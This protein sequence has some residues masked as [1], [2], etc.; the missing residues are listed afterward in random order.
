[1]IPTT[2]NPTKPDPNKFGKQAYTRTNDA[3]F[4]KFAAQKKPD[5]TFDYVHHSS[6]FVSAEC[7]VQALR[8]IDDTPEAIAK[9]QALDAEYQEWLRSNA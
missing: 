1:M 3:R 8:F 5:A 9:W 7:G 4:G 6:E 2:I